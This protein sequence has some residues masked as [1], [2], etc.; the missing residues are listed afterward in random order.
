M[1]DGNKANARSKG[2]QHCSVI[3]FSATQTLT[4]QP[5]PVNFISF[6]SIG[7]YLPAHRSTYHIRTFSVRFRA[8]AWHCC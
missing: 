8:L 7:L 6:V 5:G 4:R 2:S 1:F 3:V